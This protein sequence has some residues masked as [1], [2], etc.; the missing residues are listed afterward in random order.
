VDP[1]TQA[2]LGAAWAQPAARAPRLRIAT[3]IGCIAGMAPDLDILIRS[4][5]D[6]LLTLEYH[7]QFTHSLI[8]IPAGAALCALA[9]FRLFRHQITFAQCYLFC[10]LGYASH[11]VLDACTT[12]GT[13]LFWPFSN[14]RIA[15]NN[16]SVVDPMF[17]VP[18]V[19]LVLI[20]VAKRRSRFAAAGVCW[21]IFYLGLGV[22][23]NHRAIDV[24]AELASSR[25]HVP[26]RLEAKP[27]FASILVWKTIY[28]NDGK[29]FVDAVRTGWSTVVFEGTSVEK[30]DLSRHLPWLDTES[31]Q[32]TDL[33]RFRWFSNDYLAPDPLRAGHIIDMRYSLVPNR[34]DGFWAIVLREDAAFNAHVEYVTMRDRSF[35]E[36]GILFDMVFP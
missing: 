21:A 6:P 16:V 19:A 7:R 3:L 27:A 36:G 29:Y 22:V 11:G 26:I 8:F 17:T 2:A 20:G 30:L 28:E 31:Q 4:P 12:Y 9:L 1:L 5:T 25:G 13:Q 34:A 14:A 33:E 24:G 18:L 10:L 32:A 35:A 15:W 23:Q